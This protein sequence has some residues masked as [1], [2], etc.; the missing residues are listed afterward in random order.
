MAF[1]GMNYLAVVLAAVAAWLLGAAW[2]GVLAKPWVAAQGKT[3]EEFKAQQEEM[4]AGALAYAPF[5]IAFL[6]ELAMAWML[7]GVLGH[8]GPGQVTLRNG[9]ITAF[10]LWL[11]FVVTTMAVNYAFGARRP[12]LFAI[13]AGHWLAVLLVEGAI[14]GAMGVR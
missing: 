2:Y 14:I 3:M 11:G 8:L 13:D 12:M 4:R 7:A 9:V 1:A 10:F 6:A 5:M